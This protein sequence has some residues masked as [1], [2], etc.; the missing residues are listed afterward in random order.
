MFK[1][2]YTLCGGHHIKLVNISITSYSYLLCECGDIFLRKCVCFS[3]LVE[4]ILS[5]GEVL[6]RRLAAACTEGRGERSVA[7]IAQA[8]RAKCVNPGDGSNWRCIK[9]SVM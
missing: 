3:F 6:E 5:E 9:E 7:S 8:L 1:Y 4:G 2:M